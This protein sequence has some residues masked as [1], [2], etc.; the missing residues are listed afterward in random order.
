MRIFFPT[1]IG[2]A[3]GRTLSRN[4][5]QPWLQGPIRTPITK[6]RPTHKRET[7]HT[8]TVP[9]I[10]N[11]IYIYIYICIYIYTHIFRLACLA[12]FLVGWA[13]FS[14]SAPFAWSMGPLDPHGSLPPMV[15]LRVRFWVFFFTSFTPPR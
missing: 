10:T 5:Y 11:L 7:S 12:T 6:R 14:V 4:V 15:F 13:H 8:I 9:K 1:T 2:L 3:A